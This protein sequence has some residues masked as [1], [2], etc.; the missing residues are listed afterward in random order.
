MKKSMKYILAIATAISLSISA[1]P[2]TSVSAKSL[3]ELQKERNNLAQQTKDAKSKLAEA[4]KKQENVMSEIQA[5]DAVVNA[6]QREVDEAQA[7]LDDI[8]QRLE[9]SK[10]AYEEATQKRE[11]QFETLS[12]R[13]QYF[14]ENSDLSYLEIVLTSENFGDMI[15]RVQYMDD[16]MSYDNTMLD[17]L[18][19]TQEEISKRTEEIREEREQ[20]E[21][22]L[23]VA[24]DKR[25]ELNGILEEKQALY[26]SYVQDEAKYNE[27]VASNEKASEEAQALINKLLAEQAAAEA[28]AR[29]NNS[30][31]TQS[32]YVYTGGTLN[33]PVPSRAAS[34][35]SLSS[36]YV[37][38]SRPIG[39]GTEFHTGYDI[40]ASYGSAVVAAE[41]G[42]VIYAG[43]MNGYGNTVM[44]S[45]GSGLVTLYGHNSSLTVSKGDT[46]SRGQQI[47]KIGSTGNSTGNH[48]HFEVRVNGAHTNPAPYLGVSNI[49]S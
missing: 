43:W 12:G 27:I 10:Q 5:M 7:D 20:S 8:N 32:T 34:S 6:A 2:N 41:A 26:N 33:W 15:R 14:Y 38:R 22:L 30:A 45:H 13:M 21:Y 49:A 47:A 35:S 29:A 3:S 25:N 42:T 37:S 40:P 31:S 19:K 4:Q 44:I 1:L 36:G 9:E 18:T 11:Q 24:E 48:C 46:V 16:I 23:S 17:E 28:K 39:S